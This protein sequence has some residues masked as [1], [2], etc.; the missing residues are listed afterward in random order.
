MK[1][2]VLEIKSGMENAG[3]M[4]Q[5]MIDFI[6]THEAISMRFTGRKKPKSFMGKPGKMERIEIRMP[7]IKPPRLAKVVAVKTTRH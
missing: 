2:K 4:Y 6:N 7:R 1:T 3:V 5:M